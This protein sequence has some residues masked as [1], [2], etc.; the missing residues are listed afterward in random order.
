MKKSTY[1]LFTLKDNTYT[2][3][4]ETQAGSFTEAKKIF[5]RN[6]TGEC[7]IKNTDTCEIK[8]VNIK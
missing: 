8:K 6:H 2:F 1:R 3:T 4:A 5:K 7:Y